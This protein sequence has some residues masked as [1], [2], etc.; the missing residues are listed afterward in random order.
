MYANNTLSSV[1]SNPKY[2]GFKFSNPFSICKNRTNVG[3]FGSK[4]LTAKAK[5]SI[6][7]ISGNLTF[8]EF[9][10][11]DDLFNYMKS[12]SYGL[13]S[14]VLCFAYG[15]VTN[16]SLN[17]EIYLDYFTGNANNTFLIQNIPQT[18]TQSLSPFDVTPNQG[19]FN[20]YRNSGFLFMMNL[21]NNVIAQTTIS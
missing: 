8:V 6:S 9:N 7:S 16:D 1:N 11:K 18:I 21:L 12:D 17:Y 2:Q 13:S 20:L 14:P 19:D 5:S 3:F 4:D 10:T 15:I